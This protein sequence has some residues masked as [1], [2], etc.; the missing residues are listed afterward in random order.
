MNIQVKQEGPVSII[1]M[2]RRLM[3]AD[4]P[5]VRTELTA[6]IAQGNTS[7]VLDLA[8]VE[9]MDS[10]GLSTLVTALKE[11]DRAGGRVVLAALSE[12]VRGLLEITQLH[13]VFEI[14]EDTLAAVKDFPAQGDIRVIR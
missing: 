8:Q 13:Q 10:S 9:M 11:V 1:V 7:L 5:K 2:P 6:L 14:F 4:A 12:D 3:M